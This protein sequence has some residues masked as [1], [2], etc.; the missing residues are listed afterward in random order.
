VAYIGS[1]FWS[2]SNVAVGLVAMLILIRDVEIINICHNCELQLL[3]IRVVVF[4]RSLRR[5]IIYYLKFHSQFL[6][7]PFHKIASF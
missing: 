3:Q 2:I 5:I 7:C 4:R 1:T 6:L